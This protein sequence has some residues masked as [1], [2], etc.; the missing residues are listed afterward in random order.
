MSQRFRIA[1]VSSLLLFGT[2]SSALA[3]ESYGSQITHKLAVGLSNLFLC[4]VEI[5]K[6][7]VN[8]TNQ[9]NLALGLS[10]GMFKGL[11]HTAGRAGTGI[12]DTFTFPFPTRPIADPEWAW[13]R[14]SAE[15]QY[16]PV[17]QPKSR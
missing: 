9:A 5:P 3:D 14:F 11:L 7:V 17:M 1:L 8:T 4:W 6:N 13:E 15:T 2:G 16:G 10:G 12:V